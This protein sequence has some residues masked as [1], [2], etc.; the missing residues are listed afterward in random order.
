MLVLF[1]SQT[2]TAEDFG[3]QLVTEMESYGIVAEL[4]DM[5][6]SDGEQ[7]AEEKHVIFLVAT[8]GE[9]EPT[10]NAKEMWDYLS[11][12]CK[13][14]DSPLKGV[15]FGIFGL[16]NTTYEH[17]NWMGRKLQER[18]PLLGAVEM[19]AYGEGDDDATLEDDFSEWKKS[20]WAPLCEHLGVKQEL[21]AFDVGSG[22]RSWK[23]TVEWDVPL[24]DGPVR[25]R[26]TGK[27]D[28]KKRVFDKDHPFYTTVSNVR[29]LMDSAGTSRGCLHADVALPKGVRYEEGD[30]VAI[31][32]E[33][34]DE[35][36]QQVL[37][38]FGLDGKR[39]LR[40]LG[41]SDK[42]RGQVLLGATTL[43]HA[44]VTMVDLQERP[45]KSVLEKFLAYCSPEQETALR[46]FLE[47]DVYVNEVEHRFMTIAEVLKALPLPNS[48]KVPAEDLLQILPPLLPRY[49]SI[50]SSMRFSSAKPAICSVTCAR[51]DLVSPTGR[52]HLGVASNWLYRLAPEKDRLAAFVR[53]S[54]FRMPSA[55]RPALMVGPGTGLA[56]FMGFLQRRAADRDARARDRPEGAELPRGEDVLFTG[57]R[58]N[59]EYLYRDQLERWAQEG[60]L[61]LHV[62]MSRAVADKK[63]YVQ[64]DLESRADQVW[65]L[66]NTRKANLYICGD[67]TY[68]EKDVLATL[69][70]IFSSRLDGGEVSARKYLDKMISSKQL[71]RDTWQS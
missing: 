33:N 66:I 42:D 1:G 10:D 43:H 53:S 59:A 31:Y 49:Y 67:A 70:R 46:R 20:I 26:F 19:L 51:V 71:Q 7:L 14:E 41:D 11:K 21:G 57:F 64:H 8:Y 15:H 23:W 2:G 39:T 44:L 5:E 18:L 27:V 6:D 40:V 35:L 68:M 48:L 28:P 47:K 12:D 30:H 50:S 32:P 60:L 54:P 63:H 36:V 16:G 65:E 3:E 55:G 24:E 22:K 9:G 69:I 45:R 13:E 38:Q 61:E 25:E 29:E 4:K 37:N 52:P 56:P 58:T 62:A 34:S 17:Y